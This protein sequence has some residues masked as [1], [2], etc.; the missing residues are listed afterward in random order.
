M[1]LEN[2]TTDVDQVFD[3]NPP[4]S[5][6]RFND[7]VGIAVHCADTTCSSVGPGP[8]ANPLFRPEPGGQGKAAYTLGYL[9][10][11]LQANVPVVYG[12]IADA[13]DSGKTCA[14]TTATS[15][16]VSPATTPDSATDPKVCGAFARAS[17]ATWPN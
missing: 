13:H 16:T 2:A 15:P 5:T 6:D 17:R 1:V 14:S 11:L 8:G 7:F 12:E 10:A 4:P 9:V 3:G